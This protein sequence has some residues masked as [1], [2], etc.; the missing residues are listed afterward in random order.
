MPK[1]RGDVV[2][3]EPPLEEFGKNHSCL[4]RTCLSGCG[5]FFIF[6]IGTLFLINYATKQRE[7]E[8]K[9]IPRLVTESVPLYDAQNIHKI[10]ILSGTT[11][12]HIANIKALF[13]VPLSD[14]RDTITLEWKNLSA[15]P[16]FIEQY[17]KD[18]LEKK[19]FTLEPT[20]STASTSQ[21]LFKKQNING[22]LYI[23]DSG[24]KLEGTDFV[25][26]K[27]N[28]KTK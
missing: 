15:E 14:A 3:Q 20:A 18:E 28:M 1:T 26:V 9:N 27:I 13:K 2:I 19:D 24:S 16:Q 8:I 23:K 17:Y 12:A 11:N 6:L 21:F 22:A 7:R 4:K 25:S 10:K 5:C